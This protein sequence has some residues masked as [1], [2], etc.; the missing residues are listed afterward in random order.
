MFKEIVLYGNPL[1]KSH[2]FKI[3]VTVDESMPFLN[4]LLTR[5]FTIIEELSEILLLKYEELSLG[6]L[7]A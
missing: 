3:I 6:L 1:I 5:D 7:L 2:I 4:G